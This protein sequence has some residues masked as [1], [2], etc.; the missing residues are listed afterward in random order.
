MMMCSCIH[1]DTGRPIAPLLGFS[2]Y[3][4]VNVLIIPVMLAPSTVASPVRNVLIHW[5]NQR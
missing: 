2:A 1:P 4:L 3:G 5:V